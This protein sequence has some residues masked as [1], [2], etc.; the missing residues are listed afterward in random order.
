VVTLALTGDVML[1][2]NM[3]EAI[4][5]YGFSY[6]WGDVLEVIE[7]AD[8]R[9]IN[10]ECCITAHDIRWSR[11]PKVFFFRTGP[12]NIEV[13]KT[14]DIDFV[15]LANNHALDFN[16]EG[17]LETIQILDLAGI[18]HAGAGKN[19]VE[20]SS[21]AFLESRGT[22]FGIVSFTDNEPDW[23]AQKDRP[24]IN[25]IPISLEEEYLSRVE[26]V[27]KRARE[28]S[29]FVIASFHW[30]PNMAR[31][32]SRDFVDF[33]HAVI[34][35]GCDLFWGHSAHLFQP[36][37]V[38]KDR[39]ILYDTGD[40]VDDYAVDP[41]ERNDESFLFFVD[42]DGARIS[43][44]KLMPVMI[45]RCQ[46]NLARGRDAERICKKMQQISKEFS[47]TELGLKDGSLELHLYPE[48]VSHGL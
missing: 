16:E 27:L 38:Y 15:S 12:E 20:A 39:L 42:V 3:N 9:L 23:K 33:A 30:G 21:P 11:T 19:I 2:R 46:V 8:L 17:L 41:I 47:G 45:D 35:S 18:S 40:F 1:G 22:R 26:K 37:E 13:L 14:A 29:D 32:P 43:S 36:V 10:L 24:G 4:L 5:Y 34:D 7:Q 44:L 6:P 28:E 48:I 25:Y 31:Y